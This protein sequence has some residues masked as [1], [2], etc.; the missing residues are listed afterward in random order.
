M[1]TARPQGYY[2]LIWNLQLSHTVFLL[3]ETILQISTSGKVT[4]VTTE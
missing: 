2:K 1:V 4:V 3:T